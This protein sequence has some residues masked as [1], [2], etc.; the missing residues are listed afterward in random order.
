MAAQVNISLGMVVTG[1]LASATA[2]AQT[3]DSGAPEAPGLRRNEAMVVLDYQVLRVVGDKPIDLMGF[4]V[5]NKVADWLYLGAGLYAPLIQG[6]YGGFT[7]F[8]IAAHAQQRLTGQLFATAGLSAGGGAGG[9]SV[10]QAKTL[11]GSGGFFKGYVG[12]GYDFGNF[13]LGAN[14]AK[15]KFSRS[16]IDGTQANVFL[17]V[18]YTYLTGPFSSHGQRLSA[19]EARQAAE[20]SGEKMLT[21]VFDNFRQ[22]KPEGTFKGSFS[23]ADLQ[24]AHY[25]ARDS[26][27]YA[28]LGVGYRGLP[29]YNQVL[30]GVGQRVQLS[31]RITA[32]GQLGIGSGG[33]APE[34]LNTD[35]G[36][37]VYPRV[38]AEYALG[39]DWGVSL[40]AGYL[41]A[42]KGSSKNLSFGVALTHHI[43]VAEGAALASDSGSGSSSSS[44]S[45]PT[46]QAFRVGLFQQVDSGVRFLDVDRG[47]LQ[48]IGIQA[49][50]IVNDHWY[51]PLQAA[52]AT[53]TYLGYPGY[54]ELLA[55]LGVQSRTDPGERWQV[56]GQLLA[57]TNVHGLAA[58]A[59]A[60]LRYA[61]S[62]RVA[63][64]V[65][66]GRIAARSA[67]GNHFT[68]NSMGLGLDYR[69][70]IPAW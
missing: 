18:P 56:F 26:Y 33:Y 55:G 53:S 31:P 60:G 27:W 6:E 13:T 20:A 30:G 40:S 51:I 37:V 9:R 14:V 59:S 29:L 52:V 11:S 28:G 39:K 3:L 57:G 66:A 50:A 23:I 15:M 44:G 32:Y 35:A 70:S 8:D 2:L 16:A 65:T 62:D 43:R 45:L 4:H 22:H 68:A 63:L 12:L 7:A 67:A 1:L 64:H 61:L 36:L 19:A 49:D 42:P 48:M 24:Y 46:F 41:A 10:E 25:F 47:R 58:K 21:V 54:G 5:L 17:Q 69:F 34:R 38:A